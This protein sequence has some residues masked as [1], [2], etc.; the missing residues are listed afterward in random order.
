MAKRLS[1]RRLLEILAGLP[2]LSG[3][4]HGALAQ[5]QPK[6]R[7]RPGDPAWPS[8]AEWEELNRKVEGRLI[9]VQSPLSACVGSSFD[10]NCARVF[11]ELRNPYYL[12]DEVGLTQTLGW[13]GA[14][15]SQPSVY[16]VAAETTADV[17]AAVNFAR[18]KN[19]RLVVKGGGHSYFGGSNAPDSLLIWTRKMNAIA[20][21]DAFI[22]Q[23]CGGRVEPSPAVT[24]EAGA[25]WGQVYNEVATRAGRYVQGG[26]C[27]TVGVAGLI[28]GGGFG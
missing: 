5:A 17:V 7:V 15:T 18:A 12:G 14:W 9:K 27:M 8:D 4:A 19:L 21:H 13:V 10:E 28:L 25:M 26:G 23:G 20:V 22:G 3:L 24:V 6:T 16:A 11:K 1:R 2:F